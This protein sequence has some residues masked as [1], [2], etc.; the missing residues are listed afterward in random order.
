M[1]RTINLEPA[2]CGVGHHDS[3]LASAPPRRLARGLRRAHRVAEIRT[4]IDVVD[5]G[6]PTGLVL[7]SA[8]AVRLLHWQAGRV[9][10]PNGRCMSWS[11]ANGATMTPTWD[12]P[13]AHRT[14]CTS[15]PSISGST[16]GEIGF[17]PKLP[18]LSGSGWASSAGIGCYWPVT[19]RSLDDIRVL[20]TYS[21]PQ[22]LPREVIDTRF[23]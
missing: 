1:G 4:P 15:G 11:P 8:E 5:R 14:A 7:V 16:S 21:T 2:S 20:I 6:R 10:Q 13:G 19:S 23:R 18:P 12:T 17:S 22:Q 9:E 3:S